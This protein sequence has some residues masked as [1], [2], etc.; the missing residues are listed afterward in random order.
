MQPRNAYDYTDISANT[1]SQSTILRKTYGLLG[2]SFIPAAAGAFTAMSTGLSLYSFVGNRWVALGIF[3]VF[4]YAMSFL[5]EKNRYSNVGAGLL[6]VLTF[7]LGFTLGQIL[8]YT[9]AMSNGIELVGIAAVMTA[10]VFLTMATLAKTSAIQTSSLARFVTIG[11]VVA[12]I[13]MV[14]GFFLQIPALTLTVSAIFVLVSSALI[15]LQVRMVVE[16]GEDSHISA[17]LTLFVAIYN[18]FSSL[19]HILLSFAGE[20]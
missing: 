15:M 6:M 9:L 1:S 13:A 2:L 3:F 4:F 10:A 8:N 5:I 12:I 14:A 17:A 16:G 11:F 20:D 19:L 18:I 7:G